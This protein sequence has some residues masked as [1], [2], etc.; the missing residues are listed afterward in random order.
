MAYISTCVNPTFY[1]FNLFLRRGRHCNHVVGL[2][3]TLNH[4]FLLGLKEIPADK[5]CTSLP[6][7]WHQPRGA[8][9]QPEPA[10][11]CCFVQPSTDR[12]GQRKKP[13]V[14]C[15]LYDARSK[16]LRFEGWKR[17]VVLRMCEQA[18][19]KGKKPPCSYLLADQE[20]PAH[21]NTFFGNAPIGCILSYQLNDLKE[22]A[23]VFS[24]DRLRDQVREKANELKNILPFPNLPKTLCSAPG[25]LPNIPADRTRL[26]AKITLDLASD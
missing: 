3:F 18:K 2:L 22:D 26:T 11:S 6:Q 13:P 7:L 5:T 8:C 25:P 15:K 4:W 20:A 1:F 19:Q 14:T 9:I 10:M 21:V 17:E 12:D 16:S 24:C 23:V